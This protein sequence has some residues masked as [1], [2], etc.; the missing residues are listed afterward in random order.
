[1]SVFMKTN[2]VKNILQALALTCII[3]RYGICKSHQ[4]NTDQELNYIITEQQKIL[5]EIT[6]R[7]QQTQS[8]AALAQEIVIHEKK[9]SNEIMRR[10]KQEE[11]DN[12]LARLIAQQEVEEQRKQA[13]DEAARR[14]QK[15][16]K[17]DAELAA[18]IAQDELLAKILQEEFSK[19]SRSKKKSTNT[20]LM[21]K[22][23]AS[24]TSALPFSMNS[25][26][27]KNWAQ[28]N[29][30][31][32]RTIEVDDALCTVCISTPKELA[33]NQLIKLVCKHVFCRS[34]M[35]SIIKNKKESITC[36][37]C[38]NKSDIESI[39]TLV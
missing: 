4:Y 13:K 12:A 17:K 29:D 33:G 14:Q 19:L 25:S 27:L 10:K 34:C 8:D 16:E 18:Q 26:T 28:S 35:G 5:D 3:T 1:M 7:N 39:K 32:P 38:R 6:H 2:L 23:G 24:I 31:M 15:Q 37:T 22:E 11:K 30:I 21:V 36:P 20:T 9:L